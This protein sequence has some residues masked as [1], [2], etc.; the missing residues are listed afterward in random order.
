MLQFLN[1]LWL[2]G[3]A[4]V[5]VPLIIHLWNVRTGKTLKVGSIALIGES[6]RQKSRS[7][8]L[9]DLLLLLLRCLI[10]IVLSTLLAEPVWERLNTKEKAKDLIFAERHNFTETYAAFKPGIDSLLKEAA[11]LHYLEK[12]FPKVSL[13]SA[14]ADHVPNDS[15]AS[16][17]YWSLLKL[18]DQQIPTGTRAHIFTDNR[19]SRF[20][21]RRPEISTSLSWKTYQPADSTSTW[22]ENSYL[23]AAGG[24]RTTLVQSSPSGIIRKALN[25]DPGSV[26]GEIRSTIRDGNL[27]VQFGK[28]QIA[29]DTI[30]MKITIHSPEFPQDAEYLRAAL[31]AIQSY[32]SRKI[33]M[34]PIQ[35]EK[36]VLFWLSDKE[37]PAQV[38]QAISHGGT[39]F[40]YAQG[41]TSRLNSWVQ[42]PSVLLSGTRPALHQRI[43]F[44]TDS[45]TMTVW[46][47]GFGTP[48]L[49][50]TAN[51]A[52]STYT[53]YTHLNPRWT[54][55]VWDPE[56]VKLLMPVLLT[57][58]SDLNLGNF[59]TRSFSEMKLASS[60]LGVASKSL[61]P[62][63]TEIKTYFWIM[64]LSIF[65]LERWLSFKSDQTA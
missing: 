12:G 29:V 45:K 59:D 5:L 21:G 39:L 58:T 16:T 19:L 18:L 65:L 44:P 40:R 51:E 35:A 50:L 33:R 57:D 30:S 63:R 2:L 8:R 28:Q 14:I 54:D 55:L 32:S 1:P 9:M 24:I 61:K 13:A 17:P 6:S 4:A 23:T 37:I 41:Q 7:L 64:L 42:I 38:L 27:V 52:H 25:V 31:K 34:V 20:R 56:F 11:E 46:E 49:D 43:K 22:I 60:R 47:D 48:L 53:L 26:N 62:E 36:D 10:I 3:I 15:R